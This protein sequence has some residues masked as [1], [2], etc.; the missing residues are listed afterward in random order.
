MQNAGII[1]DAGF[2]GGRALLEVLRYL[3]IIEL[4]CLSALGLSE[5][6]VKKRYGS[7][8]EHPDYL[9]IKRG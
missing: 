4:V 1:R 9:K 6:F 5:G 7:D 2:I 8:I 3:Y